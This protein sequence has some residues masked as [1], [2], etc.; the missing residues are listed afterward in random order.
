MLQPRCLRART[1]PSLTGFGHIAPRIADVRWLRTRGTVEKR[2]RRTT[3]DRR[4]RLVRDNL[5]DRHA[6]MSKHN[7]NEMYSVAQNRLSF[8]K[9]KLYTHWN[10]DYSPSDARPMKHDLVMDGRWWFWNVLWAMVPALVIA[11]VCEVGFRGTVEEYRQNMEISMARKKYGDQYV[12]AHMDE[13][14]VKPAPGFLERLDTAGQDLWSYVVHFW[15][16]PQEEDCQHDVIGSPPLSLEVLPESRQPSELEMLAA[17]LD[18]LERRLEGDDSGTMHR[19]SHRSRI[20]DRAMDQA[21]ASRRASG[22][23][24]VV[25]MRKKI[26]YVWDLV[27]DLARQTLGE[28]PTDNK[29]EEGLGLITEETPRD[30]PVG[31]TT[32]PPVGTHHDEAAQSVRSQDDPEQHVTK[33]RKWWRLW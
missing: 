20:H 2:P 32:T 16:K 7:L 18:A 14:L 8:V 26:G 28:E 15:L 3:K 27:S 9:D 5:L 4:L 13:F 23:S 31:V 17:R 6:V 1:T 21:D 30:D 11:F 22:E 33:V 29:S 24:D 25:W 12:E 10:P 19:T